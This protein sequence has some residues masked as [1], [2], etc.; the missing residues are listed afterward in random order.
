MTA[1]PCLRQT[2]S[3]PIIS[4]QACHD[5]YAIIGVDNSY[6]V[7]REYVFLQVQSG[8]RIEFQTPAADLHSQ[9]GVQSPAEEIKPLLSTHGFISTALKASPPI[10]GGMGWKFCCRMVRFTFT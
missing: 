2:P 9:S 5:F 3:P 6:A 1:I 7:S 8:S 4:N 10:R